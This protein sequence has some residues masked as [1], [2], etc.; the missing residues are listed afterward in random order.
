MF[1]LDLEKV[2]VFYAVAKEGS[3]MK[4]AWFLNK[5][6]S[7]ISRAIQDLENKLN[8]KLFSK[9]KKVVELTPK[10][11]ELFRI[12]QDTFPSFEQFCDTNIQNSDHAKSITIITTTGVVSLWLLERVFKLKQENPNLLIKIVTTNEPVDFLTS[13]ADF[14]ILPRVTSAEG[15]SQRKIFNVRL[16]LYASP[17][18]LKDHG[19][20]MTHED[21]RQHQFIGHYADKVSHR[22]PVDWI[23]KDQS[24]HNISITINSLVGIIEAARLGYGIGPLPIDCHFVDDAGL[25]RVLSKEEIEVDGY[26]VTRTSNMESEII[27]KCYQALIAN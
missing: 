20:P 8:T 18:Y 9:R 6:P 17:Q 21:L 26:F 27:K 23:L 19:T 7:T 24:T 2:K 13:K 4:G 16:G 3:F 5:E 22:G 25:I 1:H 15:V 12:C 14:G 10:G 11:E